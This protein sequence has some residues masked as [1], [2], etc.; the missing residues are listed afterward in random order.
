MFKRFKPEHH[1]RLDEMA[2]VF[3]YGS[4]RCVDIHRVEWSI[5]TWQPTYFVKND[6]GVYQHVHYHHK[7]KNVTIDKAGKRY[8]GWCEE[9][10]AFQAEKYPYDETRKPFVI[11]NARSWARVSKIPLDMTDRMSMIAFSDRSLRQALPDDAHMIDGRP[12]QVWMVPN[13]DPESDLDEETDDERE[14]DEIQL[15]N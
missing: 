7:A 13:D 2:H 8:E 3:M 5:M 1:H 11:Y 10:R 12:A 9:A 6:D 15:A 4:D 14:D